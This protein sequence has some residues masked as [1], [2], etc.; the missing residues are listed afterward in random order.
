[1]KRIAIFGS[2]NGSSIGDT[3]ILFGMLSS[4]LA[5]N[6][7]LEI[8]VLTMKK[9]I[10]LENETLFDFDNRNIKEQ[11]INIFSSESSLLQRVKNIFNLFL[12]KLKFVSVIDSRELKKQLAN[13]EQL[14]IGGGNLLMDY[15][16]SWPEVM[17]DVCHEATKL[18]VP[19][20]FLGVGAGP[21]N[22][23]KSKLIFKGLVNNSVACYVRDRASKEVLANAGIEK[24]VFVSMDL[25]FGIKSIHPESYSKDRI[26]INLASVYAKGWPEENTEKFEAYIE[27][28]IIITKNLCSKYKTKKLEVFSSNYPLDNYACEYFIKRLPSDFSVTYN[29]EMLTVSEII[30]LNQRAIASLVTRLHAGIMASKSCKNLYAIVYQ[31]KVETVLRQACVN[32]QTF[33]ILSD[34]DGVEDFNY[35]DVKNCKDSNLDK[36]KDLFSSV[37]EV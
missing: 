2:Y 6:K 31:P 35:K 18:K 13:C 37:L 9:C 21:I 17:R 23:E 36:V 14:L 7:S 30:L 11:P 16:P 28:A 32:L 12:V 19:Y 20:Y 15:Y 24:N 26:T 29:N 10:N 8:T 22:S 33:E 3:A 27:Q 4:L 5:E 34:F 25:A 1:M